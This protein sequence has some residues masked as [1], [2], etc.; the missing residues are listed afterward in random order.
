MADRPDTTT[1]TELVRPIAGRFQVGA[2]LD[3]DVVHNPEGARAL[4]HLL[5]EMA[6]KLD[7][8]VALGRAEFPDAP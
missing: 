4:H 2:A 6:E 1:W 3:H 8:A 7:R 5:M